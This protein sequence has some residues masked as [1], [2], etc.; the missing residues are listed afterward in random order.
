MSYD[1][2]ED[3]LA[4]RIRALRGPMSQWEFAQR[5]EININTLRGY[6]KGARQPNADTISAI[7][8]VTGANPTWLLTGRGPVHDEASAYAQPAG[9]QA[10]AIGEML[11][12]TAAA[13]DVAKAGQSTASSGEDLVLVPKVVA[14]LAAGS[15]SFETGA[16][17]KAH[18]AFR[19]DWLL[20]RGNPEQMVLM[21]VSGD[22]MEPVLRNGDTVLINQGQ[23][24]VLPGKI[25][26]V[27]VEDAVLV[28]ALDVMPGKLIL[29]SLNPA[30]PPVEVPMQEDLAGAVRV[31]GRV[32][33][34][35]HEA[36]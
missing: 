14:R 22:S 34:W 32:I 5:V 24:G 36:H 25:Y 29:R 7:C 2:K 33:W 19:S 27:G 12:S 16:D 8:K 20:S 6:E 15:G 1:A 28:K 21:E 17:V 26:A 10:T 31:I 3:T 30:Y 23:T 18:Y 11:R 4:A 9:R 13:L 35:C